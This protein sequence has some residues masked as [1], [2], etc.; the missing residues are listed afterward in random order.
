MSGRNIGEIY[1]CYNVGEITG[2]NNGGIVGLNTVSQ[3][4]NTGT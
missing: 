4:N 1:N 3:N 2:N